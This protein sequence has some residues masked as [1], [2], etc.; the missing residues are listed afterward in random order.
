MWPRCD[1]TYRDIGHLG[2]DATAVAKRESAW[3]ENAAAVRDRA[4][5]GAMATR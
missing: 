5:A 3:V 1:D 2:S 4:G